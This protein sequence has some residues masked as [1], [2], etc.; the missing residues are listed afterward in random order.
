M[1]SYEFNKIAGGVLSALLLIVASKT[2]IGIAQSNH[3]HPE[4]AGYTLP[5]PKEGAAGA[6]AAAPA[7]PFDAGKVVAQVANA[8]A[9]NGQATFKKCMA[10]HTADKGGPNRV[11]PNLYGIVGRKAGSHEGF[12]Y[13]EAMKA[14]PPWTYEALATYLHN[15]RGTV[16]GTKMVFAGVEEQGDLADLL[17]Y[18]R[19]L[20]DTPPPLPK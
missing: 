15:P 16:P 9:E 6:A 4:K 8:S 3:G 13:S 17:A 5:A 14:H 20:S 1:D 11:G 7:A 18:L 2:L 19:T 12:A 10:C